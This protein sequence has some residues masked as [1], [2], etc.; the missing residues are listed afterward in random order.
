MGQGFGIQGH[1]RQV[2][3][4]YPDDIGLTSV[5]LATVVGNVVIRHAATEQE[6]DHMAGARR[7]GFASLEVIGHVH[8]GQDFDR[9]TD[10]LQAFPLERLCQ[11]F[12]QVLRAA[13]Q[14]VALTPVASGLFQQQQLIVAYD[15]GTNGVAD[16]WC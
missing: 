3:Q 15:Y 12:A 10:L 4:I 16:I 11:G 1:R 6:F 8:Q 7:F 14:G 5:R 13:R 9:R 2:S